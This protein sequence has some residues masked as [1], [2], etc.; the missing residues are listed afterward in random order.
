[1]TCSRSHVRFPSKTHPPCLPAR[2]PARRTLIPDIYQGKV[3]LTRAEALHV[4]P[5]GACTGL[6]CLCACAAG[7]R[8]A[9]D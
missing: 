6:V 7:T 4:S 5:G 3:A 9:H 8:P 2:P 1:M